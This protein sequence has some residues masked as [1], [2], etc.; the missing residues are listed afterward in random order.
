ML[1]QP[2]MDYIYSKIDNRTSSILGARIKASDVCKKYR[3]MTEGEILDES[4][5]ATDDRVAVL[6]AEIADRAEQLNVL[7]VSI[8][9]LEGIT[10]KQ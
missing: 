4:Q 6:K 1:G 3:A 7:G 10:I 2:A 9:T 8:G 5:K